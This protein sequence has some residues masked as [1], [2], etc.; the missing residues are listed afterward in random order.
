MIFVFTDYGRTGPYVGQA[1][2]VLA[3]RAYA[4]R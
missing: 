1:M 3:L 4:L 2:A